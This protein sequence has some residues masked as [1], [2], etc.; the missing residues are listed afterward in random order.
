MKIFLL[1]A[2]YS[3]RAF[4]RRV[5]GR[6]YDIVGTTRAPD[7]AGVL[8]RAGVR[9]VIFDG[10]T[11]SPAMREALRETTHLVISAAPD[12][13]GDPLLALA[14]PDLRETMPALRWVGYLSTVGVYGDHEGGWVDENSECR[15]TS[16]RSVARVAAENAWLEAGRVGSF[17]VAVLRLSGIY[18]PGRNALVNLA[19][20][21]AR[22]VIKPGQ[23]F[24][25]IHVEDIAGA[26]AF[27]S[28]RGMGGVFNV[29]DDE[30]SPPQDVI[31]HAAEIMGVEAPPEVAFDE[32]EMTPM[33]RSFWGE[34]KRVS[35]RRIREAGYAFLYPD[36]RAAL[37]AMWCEGNWKG[38]G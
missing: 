19:A 28:A 6:G 20:G 26:L 5:A 38:D 31:T 18:G 8:E 37:G 32:V 3:A 27:L 29:T 16:R 14:G 7:K 1:G 4:A 9:P 11:M 34:S 13:G 10:A 21:K 2:G 36:Y 15:P 17:P 12:E 24:N 22:R 35:N 23:Y 33:A 30:P 25:R